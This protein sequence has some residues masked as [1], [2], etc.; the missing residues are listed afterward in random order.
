MKYHVHLY[1]VVRIKSTEV[2]GFT[3][4][5]AIAKAKN[6]IEPLLDNG[7]LFN[8]PGNP[9]AGVE[10]VEYAEEVVNYLVD[11]VGDDGY[12]QSLWYKP[13]GLTVDAKFHP[14]IQKARG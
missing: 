6:K 2:E 4:L 10:H 8:T 12:T 5:E 3:Q 11:E 14:K 9:A 13:D 1:A 7:Y